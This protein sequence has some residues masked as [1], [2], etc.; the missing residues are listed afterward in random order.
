VEAGEVLGGGGLNVVVRIGE[1]VRRPT[2]PWTEAVHALLRHLEAAGFEGASRVLGID[3]QRREILSFLPGGPERHDDAAVAEAA[4]LVRGLHDAAAGFSP[5]PGARWNFMTAAPREGDVVCHNDLSPANAIY[6][7][8]G[9]RA[10]VDWDLAAPAPREWDVAYALWRF[11]P[12]Y[13]D[14]DCVR[15]GFPVLPRG[16]RIRLFCDAYGLDDRSAILDV[17]R[18]RQLSLYETARERGKAGQQGWADVWRDTRGE[19]WL[20]SVR[21]LDENRAD[22]ERSL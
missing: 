7:P 22:W 14:E 3:E 21:F 2:G 1:T 15:L 16:P 8:A 5:P 13:T 4:R 12:L 11:V 20:L 19:Q 10:F 6:G 17:V 9:P 18:R